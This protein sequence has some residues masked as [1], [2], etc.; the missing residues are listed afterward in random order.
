MT[1]LTTTTL[2]TTTTTTRWRCGHNTQHHRALGFPT[3]PVFVREMT[4]S[5]SSSMAATLT[6]ALGRR[7][8]TGSHIRRVRA[9]LK[10]E[11]D[12]PPGVVDDEEKEK[13]KEENDETKTFEEWVTETTAM[14]AKD[15]K[16]LLKEIKMPQSPGKKIDLA[17][18]LARARVD[19]QEG[20]DPLK[21][22]KERKKE[23]ETKKEEMV[24]Q[25]NER[26]ERRRLRSGRMPTTAR[27]MAQRSTSGA[28]SGGIEDAEFTVANSAS[29][30]NVLKETYQGEDMTERKRS[31]ARD[32]LLNSF[33]NASMSEKAKGGS[34]A[35][36]SDS[37]SSSSS[38]SSEALW[39]TIECSE[40]RE[41]A[42]GANCLNVPGVVDVW[43]PRKP[44]PGFVLAEEET[45]GRTDLEI[46]QLI[47]EG[48]P[49]HPGFILAKIANMS[50]DTILSLEG[51]YF[52]KGLAT[53]G[54]T[55]FGKRE[56]TR[57]E[58]AEPIDPGLFESLIRASAP[59]IVSRAEYD[60]KIK[61]LMDDMESS[62]KEEEE[63][64]IYGVK[65]KKRTERVA[66]L[67]AENPTAD[68]E[69]KKENKK[70]YDLEIFNGPFKGFHGNV[71]ERLEDGVVRA[72]VVIFGKTNT[73][74]L[75][76]SEYRETS[77][78]S[79]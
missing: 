15:V 54:T 56:A 46:R 75:E 6:R 28:A 24:K 42:A 50:Q 21:M 20:K 70:T 1:T 17:K 65:M 41:N 72:E 23:E 63:T 16:A 22:Y 64:N 78:P 30:E 71:V 74:T 37:S 49:I 32:H 27:R 52:V 13:K 2:S 45:F 68:E 3:V 79:K 47:V 58:I 38:S 10:N 7:R 59:T 40:M 57:R 9:T 53:G 39:Y 35:E 69:K 34:N 60:A 51:E 77:A 25:L 12:R 76:S 18:R 19:Q 44:P 67:R 14:K 33:V 55:S 5:S 11:E 73:V 62:K 31:Y 29:V 8:R 48:E 43:C 36:E 26:R 61:E 4:S 66:E